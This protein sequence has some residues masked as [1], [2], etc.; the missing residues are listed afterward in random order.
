MTRIQ[1]GTNS[2]IT[3]P[4]QFLRRDS[5]TLL[6]RGDTLAGDRDKWGPDSV[7]FVVK[8]NWL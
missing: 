4:K 3:Q 2:F 7:L 8:H 5:P 6:Y 1:R